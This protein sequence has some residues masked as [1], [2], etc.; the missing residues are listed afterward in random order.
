VERA[1]GS[2]AELGARGAA[3]RR[4]SADPHGGCS[5]ATHGGR[6][7]PIEEKAA[8]EVWRHCEL[9]VEDMEVAWGGQASV[10]AEAEERLWRGK[11]EG[12]A[13]KRRRRS[14][15][16][17][18][19]ETRCSQARRAPSTHVEV[20]AGAARRG[21]NARHR[22]DGRPREGAAPMWADLSPDGV[23][24]GGEDGGVAGPGGPGRIGPAH[25]RMRAGVFYRWPARLNSAGMCACKATGHARAG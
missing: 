5:G 9:L 22:T 10:L 11:P 24:A 6:W 4:L 25:L 16:T 7:R 1:G 8:D 3:A 17:S 13:A 2:G 18:S 20:G 15:V 12:E 21:S 14:G 23:T 19:E